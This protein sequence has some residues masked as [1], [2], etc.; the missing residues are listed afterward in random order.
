MNPNWNNALKVITYFLVC[1]WRAGIALDVAIK[2][3]VSAFF[4]LKEH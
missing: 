3:F 4:L 2:T 1:L